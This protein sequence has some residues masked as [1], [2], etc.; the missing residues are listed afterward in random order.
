MGLTWNLLDPIKRCSLISEDDEAS[1]EWFCSV[2][3]NFYCRVF[4]VCEL[5][6]LV[7]C[8][9]SL[10]TPA[11]CAPQAWQNHQLHWEYDNKSRVLK[12]HHISEKM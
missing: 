10:R 8:V 3:S 6:P 12:S 11:G 9:L 4:A 2:N 7:G 5:T 1:L